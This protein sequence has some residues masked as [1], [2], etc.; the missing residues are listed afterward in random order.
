MGQRIACICGKKHRV[1]HARMRYLADKYLPYIDVYHQDSTIDLANYEIVY[2]THYSLYNKHRFKKTKLASVTSHKYTKRA[3]KKFDGISVNNKLLMKDLHGLNPILTENGVDTKFWELKNRH[4]SKRKVIGWVGNVD[5]KAKRYDLVRGMI[6]A[7]PE[8]DWRTVETS[9]K[10]TYKTLKTPEEMREYYQSLDLLVVVSKS[11]G[12]PNPAL[13]AMSCGTPVMSTP[14][15]NMPEFKSV[16][17][18]KTWKTILF[19][20]MVWNF[21]DRFPSRIAVRNEIMK[22]DW[23]IKVRQW[24]KFFRRYL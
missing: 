20:N 19:E 9:K 22:W 10:D 24:D 17:P 23:S 7:H 3:L 16:L 13:E 1:Q 4:P 6:H 21:P 11:E 5:R 8:Y 18:I 14:V 2:Y 12:T 15:G